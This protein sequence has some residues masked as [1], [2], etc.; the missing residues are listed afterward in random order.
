MIEYHLPMKTILAFVALFG[1]VALAAD[2]VEV[3]VKALDGFG[4]DTSSV[5]SRC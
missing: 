2:I 4:G 1:S 5:A 3:K